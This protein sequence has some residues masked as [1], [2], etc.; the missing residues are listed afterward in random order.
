MFWGPSIHQVPTFSGI[1][2]CF[3]RTNFRKGNVDRLYGQRSEIRKVKVAP[4]LSWTLATDV[5]RKTVGARVRWI[6]SHLIS[7]R[8]TT[9]GSS[10][11]HST[12]G[13]LYFHFPF[14]Q[15]PRTFHWNLHLFAP[16]P[17]APVICCESPA[18][19]A[20]IRVSSLNCLISCPMNKQTNFL[21]NNAVADLD[22]TLICSDDFSFGLQHFDPKKKKGNVRNKKKKTFT[23]VLVRPSEQTS[24]FAQLGGFVCSR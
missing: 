8:E 23:E 4:V 24:P 3:I 11:S 1:C 9:P 16:A 18:R 20:G 5:T 19:A 14:L 2:D 15:W 12:T 13:F 6:W 22:E 17:A 10:I 7:I 21:I